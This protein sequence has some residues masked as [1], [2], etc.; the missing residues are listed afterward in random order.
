MIILSKQTLTKINIIKNKLNW[1][2]KYPVL[3]ISFPKKSQ[4]HQSVLD[5]LTPVKLYI[6]VSLTLSI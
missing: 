3:L 1:L 5:Y 2:T 4:T 6:G